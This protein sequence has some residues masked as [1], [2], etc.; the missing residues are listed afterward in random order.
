MQA[1]WWPPAGPAPPSCREG[2][3]S[4][5]TAIE[6]ARSLPAERALGERGTVKRFRGA[7]LP[8]WD[9]RGA[10]SDLCR[11]PE[12]ARMLRAIDQLR[13]AEEHAVRY[14]ATALFPQRAAAREISPELYEPPHD[15]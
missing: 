15:P 11:S 10:L 9:S 6:R 8:E 12:D 13:Y 2:L 5:A 4:L 3:L 7:L 1:V 14:E